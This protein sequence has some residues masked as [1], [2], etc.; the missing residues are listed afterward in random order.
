[1]LYDTNKYKLI[2]KYEEGGKKII[3]DITG[4]E[5][6]SD[7]IYHEPNKYNYNGNGWSKDNCSE[8]IIEFYLKNYSGSIKSLL[9]LE[10]DPYPFDIQII[11]KNNDDIKVNR[12]S[13]KVESRQDNTHWIIKELLENG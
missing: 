7:I 2:I 9:R 6:N 13:T 12:T 3:E 11:D 8:G 1:M 4:F 5:N 10:R